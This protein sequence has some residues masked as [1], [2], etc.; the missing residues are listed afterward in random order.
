V[1]RAWPAYDGAGSI[2]HFC[3]NQPG[4][5]IQIN[6]AYVKIKMKRVVKKRKGRSYVVINQSPIS[7]FAYCDLVD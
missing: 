4:W 1:D 7:N 5:S 6:Q 3:E 2:A